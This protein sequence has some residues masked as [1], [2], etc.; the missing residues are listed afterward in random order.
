M[1]RYRL[2][3]ADDHTLVLEGFRRLL[4]TDFDLIGTAEDGQRLV[5][6]A[7]DLKP[8]VV[9]L[10]I[11]MPVL[12]GFEACRRIRKHLPE[13]KIIFVTM[14]TDPAYATEAFRL[15]A[16][17]YVLKRSAVSELNEAIKQSLK[18]KRY[19]TPLL[20]QDFA[21]Q[22]TTPPDP[23][24]FGNALSP[25]ERQVLQLVAEGQSAKEIAGVLSISPKTVE[26]HKS[27]IM[28]KL[29]LHTTAELTRYAIRN[30]MVEA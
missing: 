13:T 22:R 4:E 6:L 14:H 25:R 8:D 29:G 7:L 23:K 16:S 15:G 20:T 18:G 26:F 30:G 19:L 12:N 17:G 11:S 3:M 10:D 9:L 24:T 5:A 27:G 21:D 2:L 28:Q 1:K